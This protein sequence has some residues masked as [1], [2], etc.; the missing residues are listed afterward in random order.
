MRPLT[1][2]QLNCVM[3]SG[4]GDI[5]R[6]LGFLG[7][8]AKDRIPKPV[9]FP[10]CVIANTDPSWMPGEHWVVLLVK[11]DGS[12]EFFDSFGLAPN[13]YG[14]HQWFPTHRV[15][16]NPVSLQKSEASCGYFCLYF[17]FHRASGLSMKHIVR[18]LS[19]LDDDDDLFVGRNVR[20]LFRGC[21]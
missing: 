21:I 13:A 16:H 2:F 4:R 17:L 6:R 10:C 7:A 11:S 19:L 15:T 14:F 3:K 12:G 18:S 1:T 9:S 20:R 8:F 5:T